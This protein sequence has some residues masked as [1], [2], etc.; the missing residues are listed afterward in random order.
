MHAKWNTHIKHPTAA[1]CGNAHP[2]A[3]NTH[4][5][6]KPSLC[7]GYRFSIRSDLDESDIIITV[8]VTIE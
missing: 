6:R 7:H 4:Q 1:N 2:F 5:V 8:K 3:L